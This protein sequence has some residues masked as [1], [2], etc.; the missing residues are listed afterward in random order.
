VSDANRIAQLP[1]V[2]ETDHIVGN[3]RP[4]M[5][6]FW[7]AAGPQRP[8]VSSQNPESVRQGRQ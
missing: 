1:L 8:F 5:Q 2:E 3:V 4:I 6:R 7:L